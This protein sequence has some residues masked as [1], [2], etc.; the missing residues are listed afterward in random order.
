M[1]KLIS[2]GEALID[3][4]PGNEG[5]I[6]SPGG[7]PA[8]VVACAAKLGGTSQFITKVGQDFFG[9]FLCEIIKNAGVD[10]RSLYRT[11]ESNTGLA[12]VSHRDNG[13][14]EFLFY[15]NPSA[16]MLLNE[17]EIDEAWFNEGDILHF[18]S[19]DLIDAP[20]RYAHNKA[21]EFAKKNNCIICF[22]PNIR[23]AL[24]NDHKE[25]KRVI[26]EYINQA[27]I[28]KVSDDE[29]EFITGIS[30][31][32]LAIKSLLERVD[33]LIYTKGGDGAEVYTDNFTI[34]HSGFK[35][36]A[37]DTTGAGD[38]FI[39]SFMYQILKYNINI[40]NVNNED[41]I[42]QILEFSN[43]VAAYVVSRKG[44]INIMPSVEEVFEVIN[45]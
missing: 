44:T 30:D 38:S 25:Y 41:K 11:A 13:E 21:I 40:K 8:N 43:A 22:D 18:C 9:D 31:E 12:F 42:R 4:I 27:D 37:I 26:N 24:W 39:G 35:T 32:E 10:C 14:R 3:F 34:K 7:A 28:I 19:V 2:I 15:R 6:Q 23:L 36:K 16:D 29:L 1:K 5:Y 17:N 45:K 20:V 33:M